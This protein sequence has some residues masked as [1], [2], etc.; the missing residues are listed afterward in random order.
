MVIV[1]RNLRP[2]RRERKH[3]SRRAVLGIAVT[4][5]LILAATTRFAVSMNE[6]GGSDLNKDSADTPARILYTL[7]AVFGLEEMQVSPL[8]M[9]LWAEVA[10]HLIHTLSQIGRL[11]LQAYSPAYT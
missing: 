1:D 2:R 9:A 7:G 11:R 5:A 6:N 3:S 4:A 10:L 8:R